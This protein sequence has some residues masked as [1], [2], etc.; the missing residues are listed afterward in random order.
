[1]SIQVRP[2]E[3]KV[4]AKLSGQVKDTTSNTKRYTWSSLHRLVVRDGWLIFYTNDGQVFLEWAIPLD[5]QSD[6]NYE[7][8]VPAVQFNELA[9]KSMDGSPYYINYQ[10]GLL[11]LSQGQRKLKIR[12]EPLHAYP[13]PAS[14]KPDDPTWL[15]QASLL[16]KNLG[17]V[18]PFIDEGNAKSSLKVATWTTNGDLIGGTLQLMVRV[19]GLPVPLVPMNFTQRAAK[20][21]SAFLSALEGDVQI[22]VSEKHYHFECPLCHHRLIVAKETAS[23]REPTAR[24]DAE[25]EVFK[26]DGPRL[27]SSVSILEALLPN[28]INRLLFEIRGYREDAVIKVST[29]MEDS[30]SSQD[31]IPIIR[32]TASTNG[33]SLLNTQLS[34]NSN[35]LSQ[36]LREMN[37]V[38][39]TMKYYN[40]D[41]LFYIEDERCNDIDTHRV[42]MLVVHSAASLK[43]KELVESKK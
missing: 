1:M 41:K 30:K 37:G 17:F 38:I 6:D 16:N 22:T 21:L 7:V 13:D 27:L 26:V 14:V 32:E 39:L 5:N 34:V 9:S 42:A 10:D 36:A 25:T 31:E 28:D 11:E 23:F 2:T 3:L 12:S 29:A 43:E 4:I 18:T 20:A 33:S 35:F 15:I 8:V 40:K 24:E 19:Q